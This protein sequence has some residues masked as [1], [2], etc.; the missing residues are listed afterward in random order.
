MRQGMWG[1][2]GCAKDGVM[3][4]LELGRVIGKGCLHRF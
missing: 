1:R 4:G 3:L 2:G